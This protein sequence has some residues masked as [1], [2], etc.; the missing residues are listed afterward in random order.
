MQLVYHSVMQVIVKLF[1]FT[2][3]FVGRHLIYNLLF[4]DFDHLEVAIFGYNYIIT[5]KNYKMTFFV[6]GQ[7]FDLIEEASVSKHVLLDINDELD[8]EFPHA[9]P[10]SSS[11]FFTC[12]G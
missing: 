9:G 8:L 4:A 1:G 10:S 7:Y 12:V 11:A 6:A 5:T 2:G 3:L